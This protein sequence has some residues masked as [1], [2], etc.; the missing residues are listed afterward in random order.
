MLDL[1][2]AF[3]TVDHDILCWKLRAMGVE[4]VEWFRSYLTNR[5]QSVHVNAAKSDFKS[6]VCGVPQ[7]SI[8]AGQPKKGIPGIN[9]IL[10]MCSLLLAQALYLVSSAG[11]VPPASASCAALGLIL[12]FAWLLVMFEMNVCTYHMFYM[13][14]STRIIAGGTNWMRCFKYQVY[15]LL[16]S[17]FWVCVHVTLS[18]VI[19]ND[20][21][22]GKEHCY[23]NEQT[24]LFITF[25]IPVA[26]VIATNGLM[27]VKVIINIRK[28]QRIQ[29]HVANDRNEMCI[30]IKLSTL[31]GLTWVF[32]LVDSVADLD[33]VT[34]IF[35]ILNLSQGVFLFFSFICNRRTL[36]DLKEHFNL[37]KDRTLTLSNSDSS[38]KAIQ[39]N[40]TNAATL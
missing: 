40:R 5:T 34:Y 10:L 24:M 36:I 33:P 17:V 3:D 32:G 30:F 9:S 11:N 35:I 6:V 2:K 20:I 29:R 37:S 31:T 15:A 14:A 26:F 4:S 18:E 12:H 22:Y 38:K 8:L 28:S 27:F 1:Q 13:L 7:G 21:G 39:S 19:N 25:V 16:S 23:I